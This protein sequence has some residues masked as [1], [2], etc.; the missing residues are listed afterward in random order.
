MNVESGIVHADPLARTDLTD[1]L[2]TNVFGVHN[3]T[4]AF[5]PLLRK[6]ELKKIGNMYICSSFIESR[7]W[8]NWFA[9][10]QP[11]AQ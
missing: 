11:W 2:N 3:V 1:V 7:F 8:A 4:R 5:L 6:G 9:V 10:L